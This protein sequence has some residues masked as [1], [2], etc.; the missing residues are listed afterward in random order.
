M[1]EI[2]ASL[3]SHGIEA[4]RHTIYN[5]EKKLRKKSISNHLNG[6]H[7]RRQLPTPASTIPSPFASTNQG[8]RPKG[9]Q[10]GRPK[11]STAISSRFK[12]EKET[13][14]GLEYAA[15]KI[16]KAR[17]EAKAS[18]T[19][20]AKGIIS[21]IIDEANTLHNLKG[22]AML[23][24]S[25][26]LSRVNRGNPKG[27]A[28]TPT[29]SSPM[30]LVEPMLVALCVRRI[31]SG[32]PF[33]CTEFLAV[34]SSLIKD[35][36]TEKAIL[37]HR[38]LS[39]KPSSAPLLGKKYYYNFLRRNG[40]SLQSTK[41]TKNDTKIKEQEKQQQQQRN[42]RK[43]KAPDD[44]RLKVAECKS[45]EEGK[46]TVKHFKTMCTY[47]KQKD[48]TALAKTLTALK[49]Q[50]NERRNRL[51]PRYAPEYSLPPTITDDLPAPPRP[52]PTAAAI[53][54]DTNSKDNEEQKLTVSLL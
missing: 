19:T 33:D 46:W 23:K 48:D 54:N 10:R 39:K 34:A 7:Q 41:A 1:N 17:A 26:V 3:I 32:N 45:I 40:S 30:Q 43:R 53:F 37:E 16:I 9:S 8:G 12:V 2:V 52:P 5:H 13:N 51:S 47:K 50:W 25:T 6:F 22:H 18:S 35:T 27:W 21:S 15:S 38:R 20:I 36:P 24:R 42:D 31:R 29:T 28:G 11:S 14:D 4:T 44:L 49:D